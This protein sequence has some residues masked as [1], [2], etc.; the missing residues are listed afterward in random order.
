MCYKHKDR[1]DGECDD[2]AYEMQEDLFEDWLYFKEKESE[3]TND[4]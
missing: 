1:F 4:D 2:C 3:E